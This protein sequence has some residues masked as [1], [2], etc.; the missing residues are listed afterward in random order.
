MEWVISLITLTALEIILGIDNIVLISVIASRLPEE[1]RDKARLLGLSF[2]LITRVLLLS[3]ITWLTKLSTPLL[4]VAQNEISI[5]DLILIVGGLF[6]LAKATTEIYNFVEL[7]HR[8]DSMPSQK[9]QS[10][11]SAIFTIVMF[12]LIFS[13]DSVLTAVGLAKELW[14][15]IA[16]VI[17]SVF[18]MMIFAKPV[19]HFVEKN[20]GIKLLALSFLVLIGVLL[21]AE[22][23]ESHL[24]RGYVYF[25]M[26][27]SL[28]IELLNK[29]RHDKKEVSP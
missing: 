29:R 28:S 26:I 12:D 20:P 7:E 23:F 5:K 2:A 3:T 13:L 14:I 19:S 27:F 22:G 21:I 6:L 4:T 9:E 15:M 11:S 16:A 25:A 18:I 24:D 1:K 10:L 17:L 8:Q